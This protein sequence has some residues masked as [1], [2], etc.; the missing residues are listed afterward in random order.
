MPNKTN[1]TT[2]VKKEYIHNA[3]KYSMKNHK[4]L[5]HAIVGPLFTFP[6][7]NSK[8]FPLFAVVTLSLS[9]LVGHGCYQLI[10]PVSNRMNVSL[11]VLLFLLLLFDEEIHGKCGVSRKS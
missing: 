5:F 1:T 8:H 11:C 4:N 10:H 7:Q 9:G 6:N 2:K 3:N